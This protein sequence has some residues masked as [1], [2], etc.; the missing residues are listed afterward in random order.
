MSHPSFLRPFSGRVRTLLH[1]RPVRQIQSECAQPGD[2]SAST[3][4]TTDLLPVKVGA[5]QTSMTTLPGHDDARAPTTFRRSPDPQPQVCR[6]GTSAVGAALCPLTSGASGSCG[7]AA[8]R[9][10]TRTCWSGSADHM[11]RDDGC[12]RGRVM[13]W[14]SL[15]ISAVAGD[16]NES[17]RW[18][19]QM[20]RVGTWSSSLI[21][22]TPGSGCSRARPG[23]TATPMPAATNDWQAT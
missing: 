12:R 7:P 18:A 2:R 5:A 15:I 23:M 17:L 11:L 16:G 19:A 1:V 21:T 3:S 4:K 8:G 9:W 6:T 22:L 13:R 10:R 14:S 20:R